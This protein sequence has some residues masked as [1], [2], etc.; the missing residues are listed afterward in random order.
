MSSLL[1]ELAFIKDKMFDSIIIFPFQF[2]HAQVIKC[3]YICI[4][5]HIH[6]TCLIYNI[7]CM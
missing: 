5:M 4:Y 1:E 3:M 6:T 2:S 7:L